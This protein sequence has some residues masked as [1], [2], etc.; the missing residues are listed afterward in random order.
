MDR[1]ETAEPGFTEEQKQYLQGFWSGFEARRRGRG[2]PP[3]AEEQA[4]GPLGKT[5]GRTN[6][7][8]NSRAN[9]GANGPTNG[10]AHGP[11]NSTAKETAPPH[12]ANEEAPPPPEAVHRR[13]QDH[14]LAEG[15]KLSREE[16]AKRAKN[17]LDMWDEVCRHAEENRFPQGTDVFLFKFHGLFYVAPAQDSYMCRLRFPAGIVTSHQLRGVADL[18]DTYGG[19][20]ADVTTRA[21]LQIRDVKAS[22]GA[23]VVTRLQ[24]LGIVNRGAGADNIR[25][26]TASPAAGIDPRELIDTR[27]LAREMHHAILNHRE[28]Y[29]LPRKFNIAFDGGG[30]IGAVEDTNDIGF[31]AVRVGEGRAA[32][33]GIY[34]RA[35]VGG[36]TGHGDFTRDTGLLLDPKECVP[37][38]VAMVRV[39]IEHG[40]RT[41]RKKARLKYLLDRWGVEKFVEET[42][43]AL[44][45]K[46]PRLPAEACEP[47]VPVEKHGHVGFHAQ[48]QPGHFYAGVVLPVGRMTAAAMRGLASI[49]ERHGSGTIRLTVWQNL[50]I[51]DVPEARIE[52]VKEDLH[53]LG[54]GWSA[55]GVR[56]G[57]VACTGNTGCRYS[58]TDTKGHALK[59]A[60]ELEA[61]VPLDRPI[62]VHFTGCPHSCAQHAIA[63]IGLL[64]T[65]V[66]VG[67]EMVEGY[68]VFVGGSY[69]AESNLGSAL[70]RE[71]CRDVTFDRLAD[72]LERSL[73]GYLERR[74]GPSETFR[75]FVERHS[76]DD[77]REVF[78]VVEPAAS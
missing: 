15:K 34:F 53:A 11:T 57:L 68:H 20:Y 38:A 24:E 40:D 59:I 30:A 78:G 4:A 35:G 18:A 62:N 26:I 77:L 10:T 47:R 12:R 51:S 46:L 44:G 31:Q 50:L 3:L 28:M 48:K 32:A 54:L 73:R 41:D 42:E 6:G 37:V 76:I 5:N 23:A 66:E 17:P 75:V 19:G 74:E 70:G 1:G 56:G 58:A 9:G 60:E 55:S 65:K 43:K 8:T 21:N 67:D 64:G 25:N 61:R 52:A 45:R 29:G 63:D 69:G 39:F 72:V 13:A 14:F 49:A 2:L 16:E 33:A 71:L 7:R 27:P 22:S 36:I